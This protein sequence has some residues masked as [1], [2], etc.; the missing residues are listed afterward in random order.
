[1]DSGGGDSNDSN[2]VDVGG[3]NANGGDD[4]NCSDGGSNIDCGDDLGSGDSID[5]GDVDDN[6]GVDSNISNDANC[7]AVDGGNSNIDIA[8]GDYFGFDTN[9]NGGNSDDSDG[10]NNAA[11][12]WVAWHW[13]ARW[14]WD[15][16]F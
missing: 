2:G 6:G 1:M 11:H 10:D 16:K 9:D 3:V 8:P 4:A 15:T 5:D 7:G 13:A 12:T 14:Y